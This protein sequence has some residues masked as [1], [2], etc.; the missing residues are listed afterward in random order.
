MKT[1]QPTDSFFLRN[2]PRQVKRNFKTWC[3]S[4]EV[5]MTDALIRLMSAVVKPGSE[6]GKVAKG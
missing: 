6:V 3:A 1:E 5:S 2:L 4:H